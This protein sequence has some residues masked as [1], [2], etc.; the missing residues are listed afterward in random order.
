MR[1][2]ILG[3][4]LDKLLAFPLWVKQIIYLRLY[5]NLSEYL[6]EDFIKTNEEDIFH[7]YVPVMSFSGRTELADK[8]CGLDNNI[9]NFLANSDQG[10]SILEISLNNFW[11]MEEIAQYFVFCVEQNYIRHPE[12]KYIESTAKFISGKI[13]SG[14][15]FKHI[16]KIDVDQLQQVIVKQKEYEKNGV[17]K[18]IVEI[19]IELGFVTEKDSV[20][21]LR[22]KEEAQKR[23]ILDTGIAPIVTQVAPTNL[24]LSPEEIA[25]LT[26]E[27]KLLKD[28]L[29]KIL[30]FIKK[31]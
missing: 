26:E 11:T 29:S 6:S 9:Y 10:L 17:S 14:E 22:I 13:R 1:K 23:F 19:M 2:N 24:T 12:S 25:K 7:L 31:Q 4:F 5:Q 27:N 16:G 21:L 18:K 3:L 20:A 30:A 28:R 15:F 8:K